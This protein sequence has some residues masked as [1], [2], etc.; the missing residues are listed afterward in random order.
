[1]NLPDQMI[2]ERRLVLTEPDGA[3]RELSVKVYLPRRSATGSDWQCTYE[4]VGTKYAGS[5]RG[6]DALQAT[7]LAFATIASHLDALIEAGEKIKWHYAPLNARI[8]GPNVMDL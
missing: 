2:G 7:Q 8:F 4:I 3:E 1:M 5:V 6:I